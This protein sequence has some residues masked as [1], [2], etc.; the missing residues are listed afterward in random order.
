MRLYDKSQ[1]HEL[2]KLNINNL[3]MY[4]N[5]KLN[6][7]FK[8]TIWN[9]K[10][11]MK[12]LLFSSKTKLNTVWCAVGSILTSFTLDYLCS[13]LITKMCSNI[14]NNDIQIAPSDDSG[15]RQKYL[16]A[17]LPTSAGFTL[18]KTTPI[19]APPPLK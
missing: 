9:F 13:T 7:S 3:D 15:F 8:Q 17:T 14:Q 1:A 10:I 12:Y 16:C 5:M 11:S 2:A 4:V 18:A 19:P 6:T